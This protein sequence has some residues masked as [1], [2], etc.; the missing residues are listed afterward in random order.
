MEETFKHKKSELKYSVETILLKPRIGDISR[1]L[2]SICLTQNA[3]Q[4]GIAYYSEVWA[5]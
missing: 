3:N 2:S 4:Y 1:V 5:H